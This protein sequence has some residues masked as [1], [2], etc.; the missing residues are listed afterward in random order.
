MTPLELVRDAP[1]QHDVDRYFAHK[2]KRLTPASERGYRGILRDFVERYPTKTLAD[3]EPPAG[4]MLIE[5]FLNA[6]YG[7]LAARSYN[8]A[9]S[10]LHD[11][12]Q[13]H[14]ARAG[15]SRDPMLTLERATPRAIH[16][17]TFSEDQWLRIFAANPE[18]HDQI[19]LHLLLDYGIRKGA[20]QGVRFEHFDPHARQLTI[21]TKGEKI[22]HVKIVDDRIWQLLAELD[23][24]G[25]H[26]L[27]CKQVTRR[28]RPPHRKQFNVAT[29]LL[30]EFTEALAAIDDPS[31]TRELETT[32]AGLEHIERWL[33]LAVASASVQVRR[34]P[35]EPI[36]DHGAHDWWYRCLARAGV[37]DPGVTSGSRMHGAR[38][39]AGQRLLNA[40][41]NLK[42]VQALL[43]HANISTTGNAYVGSRVTAASTFKRLCKRP[44]G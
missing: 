19:A 8:K 26:Y 21:F 7:H 41:G 16:R 5:D 14:V 25:N 12:I 28:R 23:E 34:F 1:L 43:C 27:L 37:T 17:K 18:P 10:V 2:R 3:F 32:K 11:F 39:T 6:R 33:G 35:T 42:A 4:T 9:F 13:W 40:T 20:L 36:G 29:S 30:Q 44:G 22:F 38:H 15:L 24:P 31:C